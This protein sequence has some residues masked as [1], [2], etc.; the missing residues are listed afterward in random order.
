MN[1]H[2]PI[3]QI[4]FL[5]CRVNENRIPLIRPTLYEAIYGNSEAKI[6]FSGHV[7]AF[8]TAAEQAGIVQLDAERL[9]E[10]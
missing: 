9:A 8:I 10:F 7:L 6:E 2:R 4:L 3:L 5:T 1:W